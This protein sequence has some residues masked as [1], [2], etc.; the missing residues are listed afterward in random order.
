VESLNLSAEDKAR[1][2]ARIRDRA[3]GRPTTD[4]QYLPKPGRQTEST[5]GATDPHIPLDQKQVERQWTEFA[6]WR[7]KRRRRRK[8]RRQILRDV[9]RELGIVLKKKSR[10]KVPK[11]LTREQRQVEQA[12]TPQSEETEPSLGNRKFKNQLTT[13]KEICGGYSVKTFVTAVK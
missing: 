2:L 8:L 10:Q 4:R 6:R 3:A 9:L 1:V 11:D 13:G 7:K 5:P 12:T